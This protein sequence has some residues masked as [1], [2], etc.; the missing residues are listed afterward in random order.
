MRIF[1]CKEKTL[2]GLIEFPAVIRVAM[3]SVPTQRFPGERS[4]TAEDVSSRV[5]EQ[6]KRVRMAV[7]SNVKLPHAER[8]STSSPEQVPSI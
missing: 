4:E 7:A 2:T 6:R 3:F 1:E 8:V 5:Q